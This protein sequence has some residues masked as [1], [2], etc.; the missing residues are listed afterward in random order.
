MVHVNPGEPE[1]ED[2]D[3]WWSQE[4]DRRFFTF[5]DQYCGGKQP[6]SLKQLSAAPRVRT[7]TVIPRWSFSK[8]WSVYAS[9]QQFPKDSSLVWLCF[10]AS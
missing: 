6:K 5:I 7:C 4:H 10:L 1:P 2:C 3:Y 8:A 9:N